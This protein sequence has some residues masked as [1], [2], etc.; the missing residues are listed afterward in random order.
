MLG[1]LKV[2]RPRSPKR[3]VLPAAFV[4]KSSCGS[5]IF[6]VGSLGFE[7][8]CIWNWNAAGF[9]YLPAGT[10]ANGSPTNRGRTASQLSGKQRP[11]RHCRAWRNKQRALNRDSLA[12]QASAD[13]GQ[14]SDRSLSHDH[15]EVE[16]LPR[17][18]ACYN[19][20]PGY[21]S[22][23]FPITSEGFNASTKLL[24]RTPGSRIADLGADSVSFIA[25]GLGR[26]N[27]AAA[28]PAKAR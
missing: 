19:F 22:Q 27:A 10:L 3:T 2:L 18:G 17:P 11:A 12:K 25:A 4:T 23:H 21:K 16:T 28:N 14:S 1:P 13:H 20:P 15:R 5:R 9:K 8:S 26:A 24:A 7:G 6:A